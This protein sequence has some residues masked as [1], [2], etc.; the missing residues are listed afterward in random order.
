MTEATTT[1]PA[2]LDPESLALRS[3]PPRAIRFKRGVIIAIAALGSVSLVAVTWLALKPCLFHRVAGQEELSQPDLR[4]ASDTLNG[5]PTSYGDVPRLGP[6]LPG[7]LGKPI[8]D[9]QQQLAT[10][11]NPSDQQRQ[12]AEAAERERQLA[13]LK[14]ARE[15]GLLV[16]SRQAA[17]AP[18]APTPSVSAGES[19]QPSLPK[20]ALDPTNDPNAQGRKEAF[21]GN[22]DP[23]GDVNPHLLTPPPSPYTLSAGSVISASLITGLRSDLPGLVTAQVTE[24]TYDSAT[25]RILLIPQGARLIGSYDSVV[26]FGQSRALIIWQRIV[27]PDGGSIRIDNVPATDPSGYAGLSDKVDFHTWALLRGVAISTLLGVGANLTFTGESDLV[28]AIRES[29]QQ[30]VS[31]AG[32]Q[33]TSRNLA[34]QPTITIRPGAPVR[35]IVHR[36][37]ILAPWRN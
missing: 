8:L 17:T 4:P 26:A 15:S 31:R 37:L 6:P 3:R 14:A 13:E 5:L 33:I 27:R 23:R 20:L 16:Q 1:Q 7:D 28:Q 35:L 24:N 12:Q 22:L 25:G 36:D 9:R 21:V 10:Q 18:E 11:I 2:K 30:N 32:D 34:V 19:A 29:T